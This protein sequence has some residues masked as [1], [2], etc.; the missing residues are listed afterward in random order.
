[1]KFMCWLEEH[2]EIDAKE[3]QAVDEE[4]AAESFAKWRDSWT[5]EY[6]IVSGSPAVVCVK[7]EDG[8]ISRFEV[9]GELEP[10]YFASALEPK[11]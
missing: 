6:S 7:N 1:M 11:P 5:A 10:V 2:D 9:A 3:F 8:E 4:E